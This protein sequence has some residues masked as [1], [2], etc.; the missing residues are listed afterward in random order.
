M[1]AT[2]EDVLREYRQTSVSWQRSRC[3]AWCNMK[4]LTEAIWFGRN[5]FHMSDTA[6]VHLPGVPFSPVTQH[7]Y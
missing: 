1:T 7:L 2:S 5:D 6:T 4:H 3:P